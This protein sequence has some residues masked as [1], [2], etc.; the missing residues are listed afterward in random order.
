MPFFEVGFSPASSKVKYD[1]FSSFAYI[2]KI[3]R[4]VI[5]ERGRSGKLGDF[6]CKAILHNLSF[7]FSG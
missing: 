5:K 1:V 2:M 7:K 6:S 3:M 4:L